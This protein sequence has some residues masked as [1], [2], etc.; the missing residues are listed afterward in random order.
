MTAEE[1]LTELGYDGVK[2]LTGFSYDT[3][4]IGVTEDGRAVYDYN[5]MVEW[6][7][8]EE[9]MTEEEAIEW[10]DFNTLRAL[11]YFG[12][13]APVVMYPLIE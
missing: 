11:P 10:I 8:E 2:Y 9:D 7:V 3:A 5:L 4:L 13:G 12:E 6:L 1:K